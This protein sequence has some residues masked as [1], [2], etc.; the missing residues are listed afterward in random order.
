MLYEVIVSSFMLILGIAGSL[1]TQSF[2]KPNAK[3]MPLVAF[4]IMIVFSLVV[5][6]HSLVKYFK[7]RGKEKEEAPVSANQEGEGSVS[8]LDAHEGLV[9]AIKIAIILLFF[10]SFKLINFF[11]SMPIVICAV[12]FLSGLSWKKVI[13]TAAVATAVVYGVFIAWLHVYIG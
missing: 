3:W 10:V 2:R 6:I 13:P 1:Y 8:W 4:G 12:G 7:N 5:L 9:S 11:I